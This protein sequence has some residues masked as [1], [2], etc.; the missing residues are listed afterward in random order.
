MKGKHHR[1]HILLVVEK[2][3]RATVLVQRNVCGKINAKSS[4]GGAEYFMAFIDYFDI[5]CGSAF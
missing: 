4:L 3:E 1:S 5:T 2:S